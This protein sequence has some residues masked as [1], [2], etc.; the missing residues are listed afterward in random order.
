MLN[1]N[2]LIKN[3]FVATVIATVVLLFIGCSDNRTNP[4][5]MKQAREQSRLNAEFN[6]AQY[7]VS[8]PRF[9]TAG[10]QMITRADE[11][12]TSEC[13]QGIGWARVTIM[14][15]DDATRSV[16]KYIVMCSTYDQNIG[17]YLE[18]DWLKTN[19]AKNSTSCNKEIPLPFPILARDQATK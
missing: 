8:N 15:V 19:Y 13:P 6:L 17:C 10:W 3:L 7:K 2:S 14:R 5:E 11:Y 9:Q 12:Q 16:E 4:G 18:P 1:N